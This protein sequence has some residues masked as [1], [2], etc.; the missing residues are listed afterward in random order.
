[1]TDPAILACDERYGRPLSPRE[2][3][4]LALLA[5]GLRCRQAAT[6]LGLSAHTV[7]THVRAIYAKLGAG[8]TLEAIALARRAG[9]FP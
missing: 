1:M 9:Q 3:E 6:R 7:R 5:T 4:V 8:T 2:R